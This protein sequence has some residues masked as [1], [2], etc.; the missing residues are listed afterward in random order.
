MRG[1]SNRRVKEPSPMRHAQ[2][3]PSHWQL[4]AWLAAAP[5]RFAGPQFPPPTLR[6]AGYTLKSQYGHVD[7]ISVTMYAH[8][9]PWLYRWLPGP[10][11]PPPPVA[12]CAPPRCLAPERTRNVSSQQVKP[13]CQEEVLYLRQRCPRF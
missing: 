11:P 4:P 9:H 6:L 8:T 3:P 1:I 10:P 13:D 5:T 7:T 2:R 12:G